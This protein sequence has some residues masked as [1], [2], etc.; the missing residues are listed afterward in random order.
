MSDIGANAVKAG[1]LDASRNHTCPSSNDAQRSCTD[2]GSGEAYEETKGS[3]LAAPLWI[4][5][6][7]LG[8]PLRRPWGALG[9][10]WVRLGGLL[11]P[12]WGSLG[13]SW[14]H[15]KPIGSEIVIMQTSSFF[16]RLWKGL[17]FLRPLG[18]SW[19]PSRPILRCLGPA[20]SPSWSIGSPSEA[21]LSE[22]GPSV[23][24]RPPR[25]GP[26]EGGQGMGKPSPEGGERDWKRTLPRPPTPRGLV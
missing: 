1:F 25:P 21:K 20:W 10:S 19:K 17:G 8:A 13:P 9:Y 3:Q 18:T 24:S 26:K 7:R 14:G 22:K 23:T 6:N 16:F 2:Q 15:L 5:Q 11:A 12:S 4:L